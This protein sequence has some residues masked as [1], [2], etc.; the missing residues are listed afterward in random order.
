MQAIAVASCCVRRCPAVDR[1]A[2]LKAL[3]DGYAHVV[4]AAVARVVGGR[5]GDLD[6]E[7]LQRVSEALWKRLQSATEQEI[8]HPAA[9]IHRCAIREALAIMRREHPTVELEPNTLIAESPTPEDA[10]RAGQL[11]TEVERALSTMVAE[12]ATAVRAHLVGFTVDEIM[13]MHSWSYQKARN[14]IARGLADLR[15]IL[16]HRGFS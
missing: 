9:Y 6:K 12:R 11:A 10:A 13:A 3:V 7:V 14:L 15:G 4:Q 2:K 5:S 16:R 8:E 1:D